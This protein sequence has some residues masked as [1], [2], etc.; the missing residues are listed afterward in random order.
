MNTVNFS[1]VTITERERE[2]LRWVSIGKSKSEIAGILFVSESC[3]KRHCESIS[4]KLET[5]T[6]ASAVARALKMGIIDFP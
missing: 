1:A 5:N 2:V 6:L 3:V 4:M